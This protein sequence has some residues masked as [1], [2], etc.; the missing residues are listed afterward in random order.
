[1][2]NKRRKGCQNYR[3][4]SKCNSQSKHFY[5]IVT[6]VLVRAGT[7][8]DHTHRVVHLQIVV[9]MDRV[10]VHQEPEY[11]HLTGAVWGKGFGRKK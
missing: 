7:H 1:M 9:L 8:G 10:V 11:D 5:R 2:R 3:K 4:F 6:R